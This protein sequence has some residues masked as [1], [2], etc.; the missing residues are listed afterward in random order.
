MHVSYSMCTNISKIIK[1]LCI[2]LLEGLIAT[3]QN[4]T[5]FGLTKFTCSLH[6]LSMLLSPDMVMVLHGFFTDSE[7]L[8]TAFFSIQ[9]EHWDQD[10]SPILLLCTQDSETLRIQLISMSGGTLGWQVGWAGTWTSC[11]RKRKSVVMIQ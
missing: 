6:I 8:K 3:T 4:I 5:R 11:R 2:S 7:T 10:L 9:V 1:F